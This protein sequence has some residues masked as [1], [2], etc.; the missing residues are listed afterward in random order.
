MSWLLLA[1]S[2]AAVLALAAVARVMGLGG[3]APLG[4]AAALEEARGFAG[5]APRACFV[6][7]DKAAALVLGED[8]SCVLVK[9]HGTGLAARHVPRPAIVPRED[10]VEAASGER[11][12]GTVRLALA[13]A[14]R[15]RLLSL[16]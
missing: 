3:A 5:F 8:G 12:F 2:L 4:E 11:M 9:A 15:D 14:A 16:V 10:G 13:P 7:E 1:G 6:S